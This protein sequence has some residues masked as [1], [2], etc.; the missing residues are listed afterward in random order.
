MVPNLPSTRVSKRAGGSAPAAATRH[1]VDHAPG[2]QQQGGGGYGARPQPRSA[3]MSDSKANRS[4]L[5]APHAHFGLFSFPRCSR[6]PQPKTA[7]EHTRV[8]KPRCIAIPYTHT[9]RMPCMLACA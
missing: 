7:S 3:T 5:R 6:A 2:S 4:E 9:H 8:I 1:V